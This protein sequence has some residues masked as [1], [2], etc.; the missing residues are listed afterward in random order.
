MLLFLVWDALFDF[1]LNFLQLLIRLFV[2]I[3]QDQQSLPF[4]LEQ[5]GVVVSF[6]L[7]T[8]RLRFIQCI[9]LLLYFVHLWLLA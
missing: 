8:V 7:Q 9:L 5:F 2:L 6:T 3:L 4:M 1:S